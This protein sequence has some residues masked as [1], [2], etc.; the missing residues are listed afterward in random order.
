MKKFYS[1]TFNIAFIICFIALF[2]ENTIKLDGLEQKIFSLKLCASVFLVAAL[3]MRFVCASTIKLNKAM[4]IEILPL[5]IYLVYVIVACKDYKLLIFSLF[6]CS[7]KYFYTDKIPKISIIATLIMI[8]FVFYLHRVGVLQDK[9][10]DRGIIVSSLQLNFGFTHYS[11]LPLA[12]MWMT[13][14]WCIIRKSTIKIRESIIILAIAILFYY[15]CGSRNALICTMLLTIMVIAYRLGALKRETICRIAKF[16]EPVCCIASFMLLAVFVFIP[17]VGTQINL[18][19]NNRIIMAFNNFSRY[20]VSLINTLQYD[21]YMLLERSAQVDNSYYYIVIRYGILS[22]LILYL[23]FRGLVKAG[24]KYNSYY[25][26]VVSLCALA[27]MID[28]ILFSYGPFAMLI[29]GYGRVR[30]SDEM[31]KKENVR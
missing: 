8:A 24:N 17:Q 28:G 10:F 2:L 21:A 27:I 20:G 19:F 23:V 13:F 6:I 31:R 12:I 30:S 22:L 4:V 14:F 1:L 29:Y 11:K 9:T 7:A 26:M 25:L 3:A 18:A 15:L 16:S 5:V